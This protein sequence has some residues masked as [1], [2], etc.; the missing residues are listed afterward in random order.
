[1]LSGMRILVVEDDPLIAPG[2]EEL[3]EGAGHEVELV[4]DGPTAVERGTA[5]VFD[6]V[7]LDL[8]LPGLPGLEVLE[9]LRRVRP[10]LPVLVLT[11]RGDTDDVVRGLRRGADDY[12]VK[13]FRAAELLA[14]LEALHRRQARETEEPEQLELPGVLVDLG[15]CTVQREGDEER[16]LTTR[17]VGILRLLHGHRGRAVSR[18]ELLEEVWGVPGNLHTRTVDMAVLGLRRKIEAEPKDPRIIVAVPGV[19]YAWGPS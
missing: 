17:E 5:S 16:S 3:L 12:V 11:A 14:R 15:R 1:M 2:L 13:P 9:R 19:G 8:M 6:V 4:R 7:L 18:S 10:G